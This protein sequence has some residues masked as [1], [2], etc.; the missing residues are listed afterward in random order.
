MRWLSRDPIGY[1]GGDN[2][3]TYVSN[4]PIMFVDPLG[5]CEEVWHDEYGNEHWK[6]CALDDPNI[7]LLDLLPGYRHAKFIRSCAK[8]VLSRSDKRA[9]RSLEKRL[10]EHEEK[11]RK[12]KDNPELYDNKKFLADPRN[13]SRRK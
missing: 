12:Y 7:E 8:K 3:Y 6:Q 2:Q 4:S 9:R 5:L 10:R 1:E 11:L 13:V